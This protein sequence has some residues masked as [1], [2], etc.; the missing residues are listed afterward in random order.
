MIVLGA[1]LVAGFGTVPEPNHTLQDLIALYQRPSFI[2]YFS[3]VETF[4]CV[5]LF[6]TH[7]VEYISRKRPHHWTHP[8]LKMWLGI[9]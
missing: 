9:R 6:S 4:T 1:G 5:G 2:V 7:V 8:D 3:L